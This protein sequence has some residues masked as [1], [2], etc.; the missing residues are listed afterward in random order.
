MTGSSVRP[1]LRAGGQGI[2]SGLWENVFNRT[3]NHLKVGRLGVL[4]PDGRRHDVE[5]AEPGPAAELEIRDVKGIQ[6]LLRGG[7]IGFAEAYM[8]GEVDSP[9][10]TELIELAARN[11]HAVAAALS[12]KKLVRAWHRLL[13]LMRP[14]TRSGAKRNIAY[15]YDLG[16]A[17]YGQWLDPS[18][19]YS[20]AYFERGATELQA[21]QVDK[22]RRVAELAELAPGKHV[23]EIGCGWG[24]FAEVAARDFG[25]NVTGLTLSKE[26]LAFAEARM[27]R[28]GLSDRVELRLQDY[29]DCPGRFD[30]I[31][32]IEMFEA[33]GEAHW[34]RYFDV[35]RERLNQGGTAVLQIITIA[36]ERFDSYRRNAD[37]IQ[38]YIFPGG[39]LPTSSALRNLA[40]DSGL[41]FLGED[42]FANS[43]A[44]TLREWRE[45]FLQAW[46]KIQPL[47]FD[48]RFRRMWTYYLAYCEAGFK[49]G[50]IDVVHLKLQR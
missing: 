29:R 45:S 5:G 40:R 31:V 44:R 34:R 26:Q 37:F 49:A 24:G 33:V 30:S 7:D 21:A 9:D 39:M 47:G 2:M 17:F 41:Q 48:E 38:R 32:S 15:H 43:Y 36:E 27:R 50:S 22:Y 3:L 19:T 8:A 12:G 18:M 42:G 6:R 1:E 20:S 23:L 25:C 11:E 4:F 13:H 35:L 16:N 14:N 28:Q 10:L 46:P